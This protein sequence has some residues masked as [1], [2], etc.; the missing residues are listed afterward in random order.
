MA[1]EGILG[2]K[3]DRLCRK[4]AEKDFFK[5]VNLPQDKKVY[6]TAVEGCL[7]LFE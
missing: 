3:I 4:K 5:L 1:D 7:G 2:K 6:P